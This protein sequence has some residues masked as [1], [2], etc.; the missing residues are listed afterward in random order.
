MNV[1]GPEWASN[2]C[3]GCCKVF[4]FLFVKRAIV[5]LI[6]NLGF[7]ESMMRTYIQSIWNILRITMNAINLDFELLWV[8]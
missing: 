6:Y 4:F 1:T 2:V 5:K 7:R 3:V 8:F